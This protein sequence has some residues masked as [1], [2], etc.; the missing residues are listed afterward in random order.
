M[1]RR[2]SRLS[3]ALVCVIAAPALAVATG[4]SAPVHAAAGAPSMFVPLTAP[5]RLADT[6][7]GSPFGA[8]TSYEIAVTGGDKLPAKGTISAAVLN[9]TVVGPASTGFWTVYPHGTALPTASNINVDAASSSQGDALALPNMVT[10]PVGDSGTIDV[11]ASAGGNVVVDMLGYYS[12]VAAATAGRFVPLAAP[13]R[14]LDTRTTKTPL[15]GGETRNLTYPSAAGAQAVVLNV[16][17]IGNGPGFFQVFP[18]SATPSTTSN[19]N[20]MFVGHTT[21]NQV[22]VPV[23]AAGQFSVYSNVGGDL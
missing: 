16:T 17:A 11:Y 14:M 3:A 4:A 15:G 5:V 23:D 1:L 7:G 18:T 21:A 8:A 6:R 20:T 12:P 13:S 19:L 2:T 22:I 10:V 9:V